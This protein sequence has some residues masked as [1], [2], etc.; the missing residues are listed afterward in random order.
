MLE[1]MK[2]NDFASN[3]NLNDTNHATATPPSTP[4]RTSF[5][6]NIIFDENLSKTPQIAAD[7]YQR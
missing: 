7:L 5:R 6:E 2:E 1:R 4:T 3:G